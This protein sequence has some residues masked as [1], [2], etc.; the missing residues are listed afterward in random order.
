MRYPPERLRLL[1]RHHGH[2]NYQEVPAKHGGDLGLE[3]FS[4]NGCAYQCYAAQ[5]YR[6][7]NSLYE[8]QRDKMGS[9]RKRDK[10]KCVN[11]HLAAEQKNDWRKGSR[12]W[13]KE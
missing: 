8:A 3:G 5:G 12:K 2:T 6:D 1:K 11:L 7:T 13:K 4:T 9:T 10:W